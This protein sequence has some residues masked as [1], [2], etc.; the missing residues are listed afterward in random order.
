MGSVYRIISIQ[1]N[2]KYIFTCTCS[3]NLN[4]SYIF[5]SQSSKV[6]QSWLQNYFIYISM[7]RTLNPSCATKVMW[8]H[9]HSISTWL[10]PNINKPRQELTVCTIN[11]QHETKE[12]NRHVPLARVRSRGGW[13]SC[14]LLLWTDQLQEMR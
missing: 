11:R 4:W 14:N 9:F 13:R 1:Y 7:L 3:I 12:Y 10:H 2:K 6:S 5:V 8:G